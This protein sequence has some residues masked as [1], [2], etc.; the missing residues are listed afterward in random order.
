MTL[1]A[2]PS[3][4]RGF[5]DLRDSLIARS[6]KLV[7]PSDT[8]LLKEGFVVVLGV[9]GNVKVQTAAGDVV[10]MALEAKEIM[11]LVVIKVFATDTTATNIYILR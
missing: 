10:T 8:E 2:D 7:T 4:N 3:I 11:P 6:C 9:A 1:I 5:T